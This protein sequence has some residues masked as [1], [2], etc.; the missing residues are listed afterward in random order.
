VRF[1]LVHCHK[2]IISILRKGFSCDRSMST[3]AEDFFSTRGWNQ[4][5]IHRIRDAQGFFNASDV[6]AAGCRS[7][8]QYRRSK[9]A[10]IFVTELLRVGRRELVLEEVRIIRSI[11][12]SIHPRLALDIARWM[13]V[14]LAVWIETWVLD[15]KVP[16]II[17][18]LSKYFSLGSQ[19]QTVSAA[20]Q[21]AQT[22]NTGRVS[23]ILCWGVA[24]P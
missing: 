12:T 21:K 18:N 7:Y 1:G 20:L 23:R 19:S 11:A 6:C 22:Q 16:S 15:S 9:R 10:H 2:N 8:T 3:V 24:V 5:V 13:S 4:N 17:H 14:G